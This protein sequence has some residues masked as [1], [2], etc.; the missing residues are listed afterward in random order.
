MFDHSPLAMNNE[1]PRT[2]V[3]IAQFKRDDFSGTQTEPRQQQQDGVVA[4]PTWSRAVRRDNEGFF[5]LRREE[6]WHG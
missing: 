4:A 3:N 1:F 6:R 5:L 2:P